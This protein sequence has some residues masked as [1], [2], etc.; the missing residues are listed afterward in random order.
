MWRNQ[1]S[2]IPMRCF[3]VIYPAVRKCFSELQINLHTIFDFYNP[4]SFPFSVNFNQSLV[5]TL[6]YVFYI[7][8]HLTRCK[9]SFQIIPLLFAALLNETKTNLVRIF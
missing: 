7:S 5:S 1:F 6:S 4:R 2:R 9:T 8:L 3:G